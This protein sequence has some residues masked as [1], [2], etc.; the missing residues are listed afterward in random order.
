MQAALIMY[1]LPMQIPRGAKMK[2]SHYLAIA[3]RIFSI[4][5]FLYSLRQSSFLFQY[6]VDV[7]I[8]ERR[9]SLLFVSGTTLIPF[10]IAVILWLFPVSVAKSIVKPEVDQQIEPI[11][12]QSALTVLVLVIGLIAFYYAVVDSV[13]WLTLWHMSERSTF[14][15]TPL[16]L[17]TENKA[18]MVATAIELCASVIILAKARSISR[19][20]LSLAE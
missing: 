3:V 9:A 6:L 13:F 5:L 17:S 12:P 11:Q 14:S 15:G 7:S 8:S 4:V 18:S 19:R 10:V 1:G 2:S 20:M 16:D